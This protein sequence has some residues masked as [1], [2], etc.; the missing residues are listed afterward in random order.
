MDDEENLGLR[1]S[2]ESLCTHLVPCVVKR[3]TLFV[4]FVGQDEQRNSVK[5]SKNNK[6]S[7]NRSEINMTIVASI[8]LCRT[9][10]LTHLSPLHYFRAISFF[11]ASI[12]S[13]NSFSLPLALSDLAILDGISTLCT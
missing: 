1:K 7:Q 6:E 4:C 2:R 11:L 8:N 5:T 3:I 13:P 12:P 9:T 10:W